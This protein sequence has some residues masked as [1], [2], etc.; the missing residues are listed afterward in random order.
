VRVTAGLPARHVV[1][2]LFEVPARVLT[3]ADDADALLQIETAA[4]HLLRPR[5]AD[6]LGL[7]ETQRLLDELEQF[8]PATVRNVVPKPVTLT[9]LS[10][11]LRRAR[12]A[13][14]PTRHHT[15]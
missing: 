12:A 2:S 1:V 6:F 3:L 13:Q 8:A 14:I 9:L 5:A 10:D 11:I 4:T 15:S 7:A